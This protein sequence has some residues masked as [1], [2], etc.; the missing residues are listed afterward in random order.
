MLEDNVND[1][2]MLAAVAGA[3]YTDTVGN[4]MFTAVSGMLDGDDPDSSPL[5]YGIDGGT[6]GLSATTIGGTVYD[7]ARVSNFGTLHVASAS[8]D[9]IFVPRDT[10]IEALKTAT[11]QSFTFTVSAGSASASQNFV[12]AFNGADDAPVAAMTNLSLQT[13]EVGRTAGPGRRPG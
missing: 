8:G 12:I 13:N 7:V 6:T 4:D 11:T 9:Y 1:A 5:I 3:T 10:A 2:P